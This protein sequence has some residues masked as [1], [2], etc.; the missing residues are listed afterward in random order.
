MS[1]GITNHDQ[2]YLYLLISKM[3]LLLQINISFID[4]ITLKLMFKNN[5]YKNLKSIES[6]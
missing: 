2:L 4:V 6:G 5:K 1:T 3:I